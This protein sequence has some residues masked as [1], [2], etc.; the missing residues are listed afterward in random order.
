MG[1]LGV[2]Y[3]PRLNGLGAIVF[4]RIVGEIE[5]IKD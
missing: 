1:S 3:G 4:N 2:A 5:W